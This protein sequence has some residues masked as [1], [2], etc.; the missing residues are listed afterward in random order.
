MEQVTFYG[1]VVGQVIRVRR[2]LQGTSLATMATSLA[3]ASASGW[4]RV[5]TGDTA[6]TLAQLRKAAKTFGV[7]PWKMVR[8]A[9]HLAAQLEASGV[10][11]HDDKPKNLGKW[12]LGG[13][14]ILA[15]LAGVA[16]SAGAAKQR[17]EQQQEE[18][19]AES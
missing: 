6:I 11:V 7:E 4:S 8:E 2:E 18:D 16:V 14:G 15:L 9:D 19:E 3:L 12:L 17:Q 10:V 13:A 1:Q 5:E